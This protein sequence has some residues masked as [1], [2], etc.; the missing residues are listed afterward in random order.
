MSADSHTYQAP[1]PLSKQPLP[2]NVICISE[3]DR[4]G[5]EQILIITFKVKTT[6]KKL[7][8]AAPHRATAAQIIYSIPNVLKNTN[9]KLV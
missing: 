8:L 1:Q 2:Q 3:P 4:Y 7:E 5:Q 9:Y 6:A